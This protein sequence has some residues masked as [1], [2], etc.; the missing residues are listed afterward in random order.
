MSDTKV[1]DI[2][3]CPLCKFKLIGSDAI[4]VAK[5]GEEYRLSLVKE[6]EE[7]I[8]AS[9]SSE[10]CL[11]KIT[12]GSTATGYLVDIYGDGYDSDATGTGTLQVLD[13]AQS[14]GLPIGTRVLGH[15]SA[16]T[17]TGGSES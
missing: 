6:K 15:A 17:I 3:E 5:E 4:S 9:S 2:T 16:L 11:C 8:S 13:L 14:D 10:I 1:N 12:D 7:E